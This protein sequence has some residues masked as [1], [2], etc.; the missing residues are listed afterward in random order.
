MAAKH[1]IGMPDIL[2]CTTSPANKVAA[3]GTVRS[4]LP[5]TKLKA[6]VSERPER[7]VVNNGI[8][9]KGS[10]LFQF[11]IDGNGSITFTY[12]AEKGGTIERKVKLSEQFQAK[13]IEHKRAIPQNPA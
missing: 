1:Q 11:I 2:T 4:L 10:T 5:N 12:V 7:I 13:P 9:S 3:S 6:Q 8:G